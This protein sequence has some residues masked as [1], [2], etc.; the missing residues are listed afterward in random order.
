MAGRI[1]HARAESAY[2]AHAA[3][4]HR[5]THGQYFTPPTLAALM[6]DWV[7]GA[8]AP[9]GQR[10]ILDP[11]LGAGVLARAAI[12]RCPGAQVVAYERDGAILRAADAAGALIHHADF[13]R[14]G[15]DVYDGVVMNPPYI[16]HRDLRDHGPLRAQIGQRAG[17]TIPKSANL[18]VDFVVK[19][20]C[21]LRGGGRGAF[22]IPGEWMNANFARG[23]KQFLLGPG[24]L[25]D[26]VL[27]SG[28]PV[29]DDALTTAC[30]L[31]VE[32][33]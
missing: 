26:V 9:E 12:A 27:F 8:A 6:A 29:F 23:F 11:A 7:A 33:P 20:S 30:L 2:A 31:L 24:G 25:R 5:K 13:L 18:Y 32:R 28:A 16:R 3:A 4:Q 22:L 17:F 15:W 1:P 21:Q 10:R 14:S 19:A